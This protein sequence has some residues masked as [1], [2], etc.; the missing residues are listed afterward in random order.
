MLSIS[1]FFFKYLHLAVIVK[2]VCFFNQVL[3]GL[4]HQSYVRYEM[5]KHVQSHTSILPLFSDGVAKFISVPGVK[6]QRYM[7]H[8][9][10][11]DE[12]GVR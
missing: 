1:I 12:V 7:R 2:T 8:R 11:S 4:L 6:K 9:C 10:T 5:C 3:V